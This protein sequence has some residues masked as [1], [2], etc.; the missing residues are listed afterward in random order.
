MAKARGNKQ[1]SPG[2]ARKQATAK[3]NPARPKTSKKPTTKKKTSKQ[4]T[5]EL[6]PAADLPANNNATAAASVSSVP[7]HPASRFRMPVRASARPVEVLFFGDARR[8]EFRAA[9]DVLQQSTA[10]VQADSLSAALRRVGGWSPELIVLTQ[11]YP[12]K[13]SPE[14]IKQLQSAAPAAR[15]L[16]IEGACCEGEGRSGPAPVGFWRVYW[17]QAAVQLTVGLQRRAAGQSAWWSDE[18]EVTRLAPAQTRML[19]GTLPKIDDLEAGIGAV[20]SRD[21]DFAQVLRDVLYSF[22]LQTLHINPDADGQPA[23]E[24]VLQLPGVR[25]VLWDCDSG[26]DL[27]AF[28]HVAGGQSA[29]VIGL[30]GA[31]RPED[32]A[33]CAGH[34][35]VALLGKPCNLPCLEHLIAHVLGLRPASA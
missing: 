26:E 7:L 17:H 1:T 19:D 14:H 29:A 12:G 2:S 21:A 31:L 27:P 35:D 15:F 33:C 20:C 5:S 8:P 16:L 4:A 22:G 13:V 28:A 34:A 10:L 30:V 32:F 23:A 6:A 24:S 18:P 9:F 11:A 25:I 3:K